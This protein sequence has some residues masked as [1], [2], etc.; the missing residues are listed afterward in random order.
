[1]L[2]VL[3]EA[4]N[5]D[6]VRGL[7]LRVGPFGGNYGLAQDLSDAINLVRE[8]DKPVH[9]HF[10][11]ADNAAWTLLAPSCDRI[12]M[13]PAGQLDLVG[14]AAQ[15]AF[16]GGM[17]SEFGVRAD[18]M[19]VGRYKGA[20]E[21]MTEA[22]MTPD[23]RTSL[24]TLV[25][26]LYDGLS[27]AVQARGRD[28]AEVDDLINRGPFDAGQARDERL[29]DDVGFDDEAREHLRLA[30]GV[31]R[32]RPK[33]LTR[34]SSEG[35]LEDLIQ[36]LAGGGA[37]GGPQGSRIA[38]ARLSGTITDADQRGADSGRSGP[39]VRQ[40]REFADDNDIRAVV[41]RIDSPGGSA[42]ASDRMWHAVRR[43][44]GRKPVIV[45]V[46]NMA[47]S[48]GYYIASAATRILA[49]PSSLVGSIGVVGGKVE[50]SGLVEDADIGV[51]IIQRGQNAAWSSPLRPF[52]PEERVRVERMMTRTYDRF[53]RRIATGRDMT[54]EEIAPGAEGRIMVGTQALELGLVDEIAG[55]TTAIRQACDARAEA[56][57]AASDSFCPVEYWPRPLNPFEELSELMQEP[58][59]SAPRRALERSVG[60][61]L[62]GELAYGA[63]LLRLLHQEHMLLALPF[64]LQIR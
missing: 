52:T 40:M 27:S 53:I 37:E 17:L 57:G 23:V 63:D 60:V 3:D 54:P 1:V 36:I 14:I 12:S 15:A 21:P 7:F 51:E 10:E 59:V 41:L 30:A 42:L 8:R 45:S 49:Q 55:L 6:N 38:V 48:G 39:F 34:N 64:S 33:S 58:G 31:A 43:V 24:E 13:T 20:A 26:G 22:E 46:G 19:Q 29:V 44:A 2:E 62:S 56:E 16:L 32:V 28:A 25:G 18:L 4:V 35:S 50:F 5:R 9:C 47:A 61:P 11:V